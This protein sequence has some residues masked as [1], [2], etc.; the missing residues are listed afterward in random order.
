M[1]RRGFSTVISLIDDLLTRHER[2]PAVR[3]LI[4]LIDNDG[5]ANMDLRDA[6]DEELAALERA[7]GIELVQ[8]GPK[9]ERRVT[10]ARLKDAGVLYRKVERRPA[11]ELAYR[12]VSE[13]RSQPGLPAGAASLID[14]AVAAWTR[15]VSHIG[16]RNGDGRT[17]ANV[18][19][20]AIAAR[21]RMSGDPQG[22]QDF[23]TFSRLTVGDSKALEKNV[24]QVA[25]AMA[26]ILV[27]MEEQTR[28]DPEELLA[29]AGIRRLPQPILLHGDVSLDG[30][31]FPA[32]PYVG[33]PTDCAGGISLLTKP[34]YVL[35][36]ENFA[37]FVRHIREV[38]RSER[39]LVIYSG[40]FPS[41]PT[42]A[43][44][45][46]LAAQAQVP[47]FH[48]GDMDAGGVRIF[49]HLERHLA[50]VD[51]PLRA[52]MMNVD[53]L[54]RFGRP[55]PGVAGP[56]GDMLASAIAGLADLLTT[57]GLVHE[58]EEFDPISPITETLATAELGK[59]L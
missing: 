48:W 45:T 38:A 31:S 56:V 36:I 20:L 13:L 3:N 26:K 17:L 28:L 43:T 23:R 5:F 14:D 42:L 15:G 53:L 55:A 2:N 10:G 49:R 16:I 29:S 21:G 6:F 18:I 47:T 30:R 40:G 52:H 19:G 39:A 37:S 25:A 11:G 33:I 32:M 12:A 41:R 9:T 59:S 51:I 58:Q 27:G 7:G 35:T 8:T 22:E 34:D 57:S 4:A 50:G 46:R 54:R 1:R 24:R 44:V